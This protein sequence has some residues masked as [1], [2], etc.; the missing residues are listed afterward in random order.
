MC[1]FCDEL[2]GDGDVFVRAQLETRPSMGL[3]WWALGCVTH[4]QSVSRVWGNAVN[5][6]LDLNSVCNTT[7]N[8]RLGNQASA[9]KMP[10]L[11]CKSHS[12][13]PF[14]PE[15][16]SWQLLNGLQETKYIHWQSWLACD[17]ENGK[18][19]LPWATSELLNYHS[20]LSSMKNLLLDCF[21]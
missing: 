3:L 8:F 2:A 16:A 5:P 19:F 21:P 7:W 14:N 15:T 11:F 4:A 13:A 18:H 9:F 20:V 6:W 17:Y 10:V 12:F 1:L